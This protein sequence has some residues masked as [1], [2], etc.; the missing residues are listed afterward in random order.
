M[1]S[2]EKIRVKQLNSTPEQLRNAI[3]RAS[4]NARTRV[5]WNDPKARNQKIKGAK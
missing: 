5:I 4:E 3:H 2:R 1:D